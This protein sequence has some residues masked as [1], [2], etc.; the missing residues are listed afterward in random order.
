MQ[1]KN[2]LYSNVQKLL[3]Q[4]NLEKYFENFVAGE[5]TDDALPLISEQ[6]LKEINIPIGPRLLIIN[7]IDYLQGKGYSIEPNDSAFL[8]TSA[9]LNPISILNS[10]QYFTFPISHCQTFPMEVKPIPQLE[11]QYSTPNDFLAPL[12]SLQINSDIPDRLLHNVLETSINE[13]PIQGPPH[14]KIKLENSSPLKC[15]EKSTKK[16]KLCEKKV[17]TEFKHY[18][19]PYN[20]A[21]ANKKNAS[22]RSC[23]YHYDKK[24]TCDSYCIG[25]YYFPRGEPIPEEFWQVAKGNHIGQHVKAFRIFKESRPDLFGNPKIK[26]GP[27]CDFVDNSNQIK[28]V[29]NTTPL[30]PFSQLCE[31]LNLPT[32]RQISPFINELTP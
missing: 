19:S 4:L 5:I 6:S 9:N 30:M 29:S 7:A 17:Q 31:T 11:S 32:T 14:K 24:A 27:F 22:G 13:L 2:P 1:S 10:P 25:H 26:V 15:D 12:P 20:E 8:A 23:Q 18:T 16:R 28:P 21:Q 3:T